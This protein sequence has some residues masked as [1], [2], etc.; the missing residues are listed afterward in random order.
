MSTGRSKIGRGKRT[1]SAE[2]AAMWT[3]ATRALAPV[4]AKP[5][6]SGAPATGRVPSRAPGPAALQVSPERALPCAPLAAFDRRQA[7]LI[8]SGRLAIGAR[9]D[10]H[11]CYE[12]E[13]REHL[14]AFLHAAQA[15]GHT[16]V[17]VITGKGGPASGSPDPE[18]GSARG[19]LRRN[20]PRWL[21][22]PDFRTLVVSFTEAGPRHGGAGAFYV[23]LRRAAR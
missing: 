10:L 3:A 4:K 7:R 18:S 23:R 14:G 5:R 15:Q 20:V 6:V 17:L 13:A 19:V 12:R 2:E 11:G 9:L 1:V 22:D 21:T 16:M 8:A